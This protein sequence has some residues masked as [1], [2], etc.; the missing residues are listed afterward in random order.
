[1]KRASSHSI[2]PSAKKVKCDYEFEF[3]E[4]ENFIE[5]ELWVDVHVEYAPKGF[6]A[7]V[8]IMI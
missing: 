2:N 6:G 5:E 3:V 4:E 7:Q 1:M 8:S